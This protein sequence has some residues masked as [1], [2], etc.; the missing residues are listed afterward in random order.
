MDGRVMDKSL[1]TSRAFHIKTRCQDIEIS[2]IKSVDELIHSSR[3]LHDNYVYREYI[4]PQK[5]ALLYLPYYFLPDNILFTAKNNYKVVGTIGVFSGQ[6]PVFKS[7]QITSLGNEKAV[8]IGSLAISKHYQNKSLFYDLYVNAIL[9]AIFK[10]KADHIFIQ[11]DA[12]KVS[13]YEKL[14]FKQVGESKILAHYNNINA[15]LLHL[16]LKQIS[17]N[18]QC[19]HIISL[20]KVFGVYDRYKHFKVKASHF[21][22]TEKERLHYQHLCGIVN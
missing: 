3:L 22:W 20:L 16:D 21:Q 17:D 5:S 8:E 13:F 14:F 1:L 18:T 10:M 15:A 9:Y 4:K 12:K 6:L 2:T 19:S 7:F 11:V